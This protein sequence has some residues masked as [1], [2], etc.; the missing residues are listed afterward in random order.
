[1]PRSLEGVLV[2]NYNEEEFP[3]RH[4]FERALGTSELE[5][6]HRRRPVDTRTF[7]DRSA[8]A[9]AKCE[10]GIGQAI[11][12]LNDFLCM[13]VEP[14]LGKLGVRQRL[15]TARVHY[16]ID[17]PVLDR[18]RAAFQTLGESEFLSEWYFAGPGR[19]AF[20]RDSDYRIPLEAMNLW[21]PMTKC[22]GT[23]TLWVGGETCFG[24]DAMPMELESGQAAIFRGS[25]R[26]HGVLW[27]TSPATRVS[28]DLRFTLRN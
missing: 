19:S 28:F 10:A 8:K 5:N 2:V 25:T 7:V 18:E 17:D 9:R 21:V 20:H 16:S 13:V 1:M 22:Y 4:L 3:F 6:V 23:N 11:D 24:R 15:P 27:N 26:W 14:K 12:L